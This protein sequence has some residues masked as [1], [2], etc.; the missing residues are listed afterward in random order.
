MVGIKIGMPGME[1]LHSLPSW[2]CLCFYVCCLAHFVLEKLV[3]ALRFFLVLYVI[4]L[5]E[6]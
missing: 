1:E 4:L 5:N 6:K 2:L 3:F